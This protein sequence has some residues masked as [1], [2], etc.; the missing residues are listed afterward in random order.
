MRVCVR[1][2]RAAFTHVRTYAS[3][4][5]GFN[6]RHS[7]HQRLVRDEPESRESFITVGIAFDFFVKNGFR[8]ST[9]F[10]PE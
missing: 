6:A 1:T 8:V 4:T 7:G 10:R 5:H 9:S 2:H 3:R